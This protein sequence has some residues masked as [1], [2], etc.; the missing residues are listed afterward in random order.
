MLP[1]LKKKTI[2]KKEHKEALG[3]G[4]YVYSLDCDDN[5]IGICICPV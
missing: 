2:K 5:I 1:T 3:G 4:V